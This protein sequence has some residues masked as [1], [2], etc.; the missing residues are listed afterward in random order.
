MKIKR[1]IDK[2]SRGAMAQA[3]SALGPEAVILSNKRVGNQIELVAAIDIDEIARLAESSSTGSADSP[4]SLSLVNSDSTLDGLQR[5]LGQLRSLV[6]GRLSRE[7]GVSIADS[8]E[9]ESSENQSLIG[10]L[11]DFG[12]SRNSADLVAR[13]IPETDT[14]EHAWALAVEYLRD[15]LP[16]TVPDS[17][18]DSGGRVALVGTTG[19][20]KTTCLAK[21]AARFVLRQGKENLA[22]VS[23]DCYRVGGQEQL[24]AFADYLDV[25]LF[26]ASDARE[27]RMVL[28]QLQHKKMVLVDTPGFSQKDAQLGD[29]ISLLRG[30]GY[31]ID[32]YL[33]LPA[34][35]A[36]RALYEVVNAYEKTALA[37]AVVTKLD[38]AVELGGVIDVAVETRLPLAYMGVGQKVPEDLIPLDAQAFMNK[39]LELTVAEQPTNSLSKTLQNSL[40]AA[41]NRAMT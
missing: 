26:V 22:I 21:I 23:T 33:V 8:A 1:F 16:V 7:A 17:M 40:A 41:M 38:E 37:G 11:L 31:T 10:R 5:E 6:E 24:Q 4:A 25:P 30:S 35:G 9:P 32:P 28:D 27:L 19:V 2:D 34:T 36:Q 15:Q 29:Q 13:Q 39:A 3:R 12:L 14:T 18:V 20:G